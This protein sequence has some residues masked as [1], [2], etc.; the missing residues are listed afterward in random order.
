MDL[1]SKSDPFIVLYTKD[2]S[3]GWIE[4]G[5]TEVITNTHKYAINSVEFD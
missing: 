1:L 5:R 4:I 2:N 3:G